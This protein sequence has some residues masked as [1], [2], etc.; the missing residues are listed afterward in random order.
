MTKT[1]RFGVAGIATFAALGMSTMAHAQETASADATAEI[2]DVLEIDR[3]GAL[4]FGRI[5]AEGAGTAAFAA[6]EALDCSENLLWLDEGSQPTFTVT[7]TADRDVS[8][9]ISATTIELSNGGTDALDSMDVTGLAASSSTVTLTDGSADFTV[10]GT[11]NV[12]A[13]QNAGTYEGE[14]TV[15]VDY[16]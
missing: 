15:Q 3:E 5:I 2:L 11:L 16:S 13:G 8:V 1:I 7:G 14:L 4:D 6:G 9:T 12:Q 10:G